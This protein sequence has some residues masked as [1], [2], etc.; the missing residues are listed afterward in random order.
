M[1]NVITNN[2]KRNF[3]AYTSKWHY[4]CT[5][6]YC[7]KTLT[8]DNTTSPLS[9]AECNIL[10]LDYASVWPQPTG[11]ISIEN[12]TLINP[13]AF[14]YSSEENT[15]ISSL[16]KAAFGIFTSQFRLQMPCRAFLRNSSSNATSV[17]VQFQ[18]ADQD[19]EQLTFGTNESYSV[20]GH[21]V[22]DGTI[23]ITITAQTFFGARHA[24]ETLSQL[25]IYDDLRKR[26]LLPASIAVS[27][28]PAFN[29][30]GVCLDTAR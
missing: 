10:C 5:D 17:Q 8:T 29:W 11:N 22:D 13:S 4:E 1:N 6:G 14:S 28:A 16:V 7:E 15:T 26:T 25:V 27:D 23:N 30:R 2:K 3:S 9:L 20:E 21:A 12:L 19:T 18:I 24:L